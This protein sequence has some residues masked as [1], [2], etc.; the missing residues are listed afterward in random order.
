[1]SRALAIAIG[2]ALILE[3]ILLLHTVVRHS[4]AIDETQHILAGLYY[5]RQGKSDFYHVNPPLGR[6]WTALPLLPM[7]PVLPPDEEPDQARKL[8]HCGR[9][10]QEEN[11][12]L[13]PSL[14]IG[15]RLS[16]IVLF[17]LGTW[18]VTMWA[19]S[20][21]G[22]AAGLIAL[23]LWLTCPNLIGWSTIVTADLAA[24]VA[25]LGMAMSWRWYL[26]RPSTSR[27]VVAAVL[28]A[29]GLATKFSLLVLPLVLMPLAIADRR[30]RITHGLVGIGLALVLINAVYLFHGSGKELG[31]YGFL[32]KALTGR[33]F[34]FGEPANR[35]RGTGIEHL[36]VP[37]PADFV[38]G[39]DLQ[40]SHSDYGFWNYLCGEWKHGGWWY[41]YLVAAMVKVPLGTWLLSLAALI[42]FVVSRRFRGK[43]LDEACLLLPPAALLYLISAQTGINGHFRYA[44]PCLPFVI[45]SISRVGKLFDEVG[46]QPWKRAL[47]IGFVVL[48]LAYNAV[49]VF[50]HHP[51]YVSYFNAIGGGPENGWRWLAESNI[52]CGQDLYFLK[53]WLDQHPEAR[54]LE[55]AYYGGIPPR[56]AGLDL[57][58]IAWERGPQPGWFAVSINGLIGMRLPNFDHP[59]A[60]PYP[61][62]ALRYSRQFTPVAKAGYSIYIYHV[63][64]DEANRARARLGMP[65]LDS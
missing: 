35:F 39:I 57:P 63:S 7:H 33:Q 61:P 59:A 4:V 26:L 28:S 8:L 45:V 62:G 49:D 1:M 58:P 43:P 27:I 12:D 51:H 2:A 16:Q 54:P 31:S 30:C 46:R 3:A 9:T 64:L 5:I 37:L 24:A 38:A 52:D 42:L 21:F 23:A 19:K 25:G 22:G 10:F 17:F 15:A 40:K 65:L 56:L 44:L 13:L 48:F 18:L 14:V 29:V 20:L 32:C 55:L 34:G 36:P 53:E 6:A 50:R 11:A 60:M 47:P 41:Y